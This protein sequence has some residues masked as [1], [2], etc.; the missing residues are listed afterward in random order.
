VFKHLVTLQKLRNEP[1]PP[2]DALPPPAHGTAMREHADTHEP[3]S[4]ASTPQS[5][6]QFAGDDPEALRNSRPI[7]PRLKS[8]WDKS[9]IPSH[10]CNRSSPP[11]IRSRKP[12]YRA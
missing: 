10:V 8:V 9:G 7:V 11:P 1:K 3:S 5:P 4:P 6:A 2:S 12:T